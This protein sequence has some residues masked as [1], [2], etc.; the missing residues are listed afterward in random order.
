[1]ATRLAVV[2]VVL[3]HGSGARAGQLENSPYVWFSLPIDV[4]GLNWNAVPVSC[5]IDFTEILNRLKVPGAVDERSLRLY[6]VYPDGQEAEQPVQFSA[7]PQPGPSGRRLLPGTAPAVSYLAETTAEESPRGAKVA[8]TLSWQRFYSGLPD[9]S[10]YR[11]QFGVL[12]AGRMIQV[13]FPPQN[14]RA[15]DDQGRATLL[16]SFPRM[17]IQPQWPLEGAVHLFDD[18]Q[19]VT[20]Y[21]VGP[22]LAGLG[23]PASVRRPFLYPVMGLD[24]VPLTEFG[25][26]HDPTG[27]HAHHYS[28]W[29]AHASVAGRDFWSEKGGIIAHDQFE[30][31]EDGPVFCRLV[32]TTRWV[33]DKT[34][35]LRER[36]SLVVYP[37]GADSRLMDLELEFAPAGSQA[38]EL[39]K[40]TFGFLAVRVAQ[41]MTPFDGGGEILNARGDRNEQG[42]HLKRAE[43]LDLSGPVAPAKV[44]HPDPNRV[45]PPVWGGIALFDHASNVNHPTVWHCRNDG[46]A[47]ASFSA[48]K[49]YTLKPGVRL[50]LRYRIIL[51]RG[52][53]LEAQVARHYNDGYRP[54]PTIRLGTPTKI[55]SRPLLSL[56]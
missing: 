23:Q 1:M 45:L 37:A 22:L 10:R 25:K 16:R 44:D 4:T 14:L 9:K 15:F 32:N 3:A 55:D 52:N 36:R 17:Q 39:G 6:R 18:R 29:I 5:E 53:A 56:H 2:L 51:H 8:G 31:M 49:P 43:W 30:L 35:C 46:W 19:L 27:S 48:E 33:F 42:A 41:S 38:V 54:D 12:R 13:P 50:R 20:S 28:L 24:G 21:H 40:T 26:P 7:S 11:L 34:E 47:G